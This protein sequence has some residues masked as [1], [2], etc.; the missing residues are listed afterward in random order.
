MWSCSTH[1]SA[2]AKCC[3]LNPGGGEMGRA[4]ARTANPAGAKTDGERHVRGRAP[5]NSSAD[6]AMLPA[7]ELVADGMADVV[8]VTCV[9]PTLEVVIVAVTA[10]A[11][12]T[13]AGTPTADASG[14]RPDDSDVASILRNA[15]CRSRLKVP[16]PVY[17]RSISGT[18]VRDCA[19]RFWNVSNIR[20]NSSRG[21][22][23][24]SPS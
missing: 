22:M 9:A 15:T 17:R 16:E 12:A 2:A 24:R 5:L 11:V 4:R 23:S 14:G 3:W 20:R 18:K 8:M 1:L 6:T 21:G 7:A 10:V 13:T 19:E